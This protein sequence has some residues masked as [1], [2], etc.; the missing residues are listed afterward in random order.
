MLYV[1]L[2]LFAIVYD[3]NHVNYVV[4]VLR[5]KLHTEEQKKMKNLIHCNSNFLSKSQ[6]LILMNFS[7]NKKV[8]IYFKL[9]H[10]YSSI[11]TLLFCKGLLST[12]TYIFLTS[13]SFPGG[14]L[15]ILQTSH[16]FPI[17]LKEHTQVKIQ[18]I[19]L[20]TTRIR[21]H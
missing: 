1:Q 21:S 5:S 16:N 7:E 15:M 4:T 20:L 13:Y 8:C 11:S 6:N 18:F 9:E 10:C 2:V 12:P 3:D 17:Y 14:H 19:C